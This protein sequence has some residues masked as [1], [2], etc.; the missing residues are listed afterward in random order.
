M[1]STPCVIVWSCPGMANMAWWSAKLCDHDKVFSRSNMSVCLCVLQLTWHSWHWQRGEPEKP[2][3]CGHLLGVYL[4]SNLIVCFRPMQNLQTLLHCV[5]WSVFLGSS[6]AS[7]SLH[8]LDK[9]TVVRP[10]LQDSPTN[11]CLM[12]C[13]ICG[14]FMRSCQPLPLLHNPC[15]FCFTQGFIEAPPRITPGGHWG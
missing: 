6:Y 12:S 10:C 9:K 5:I 2:S 3:A 15:P 14:T 8:Y 13:Q 11:D 7:V 4:K 1:W